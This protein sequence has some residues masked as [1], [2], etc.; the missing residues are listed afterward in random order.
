MTTLKVGD[1]APDFTLAGHDGVKYTLSELRGQPVV[2]AFYPHDFSPTCTQQHACV[3]RELA[4]FN[5]LNAR[6]SLRRT[7]RRCLQTSAKGLRP[8]E[9]RVQGRVQGWDPGRTARIG[10]DAVPEP[11]PSLG[12]A[13]VGSRHAEYTRTRARPLRTSVS[14]IRV[15]P[16]QRDLAEA[17]EIARSHPGVRYGAAVEVRPWAPPR[18]PTP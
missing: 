8:L 12:S 6:R 7:W 10:R 4:Q 15:D 13:W 18:R 1:L 9:T 17:I 11:T 16:R 5:D 3:M 2:L 14:T